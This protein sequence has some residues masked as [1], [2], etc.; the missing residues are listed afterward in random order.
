MI[1]VKN[2]KVL[3]IA[4]VIALALATVF[5]LAP[6]SHAWFWPGSNS[7]VKVT[8]NNS[9]NVTNNISSEAE[10]GENTANGGDGEQGGNGGSA[11]GSSWGWWGSNGENNGGNGGAGGD[12]GIGGVI[13][14]GNATSVVGVENSVNYTYTSVDSCGCE[15]GFAKRRGDVTVRN[16][17]NAWV[18]NNVESE[19]ETG[20]NTANGG[21]GEQGGNGGS[22]SGKGNNNGG[23]GGAGGDGE[24]DG[25]IMTGDASS[26]VVVVNRVNRTV[27]RV[28]R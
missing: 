27:T 11:T 9:A 13:D 4:F 23:N 7:D 8:N 18:T 1:S 5:T 25:L 2:I 15:D 21:D 6:V 17:N 12:G 19:A 28:V 24:G 10:T 16:N 22:A 3:Y 20:E 14:T 26:G